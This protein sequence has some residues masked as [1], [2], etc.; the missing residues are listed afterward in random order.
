M[1]CT[2]KFTC[3]MSVCSIKQE[4]IPKGKKENPHSKYS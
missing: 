3:Y 4:R 1:C 2:L